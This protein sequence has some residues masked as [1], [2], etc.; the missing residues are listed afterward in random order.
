MAMNVPIFV[1]F[2]LP[3]LSPRALKIKEPIQLAP[4]ATTVRTVIL[5]P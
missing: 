2:N 1:I 3:N 4:K 5:M